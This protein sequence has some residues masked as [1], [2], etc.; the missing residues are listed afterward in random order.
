MSLSHLSLLLVA[1]TASDK[2]NN[3]QTVYCGLPYFED[4]G[5]PPNIPVDENLTPDLGSLSRFP[6][7]WWRRL[8]VSLSLCTVLCPAVSAPFF[9]DCMTPHE[10]FCGNKTK[11]HEWLTHTR[12]SAHEWKMI[13]KLA[14]GAD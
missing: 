4:I 12:Q 1:C 5:S 3:H 11:E 10:P 7:T 2:D 9:A 6:Y 14:D 13:Q 8:T